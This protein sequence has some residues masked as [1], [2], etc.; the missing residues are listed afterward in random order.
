MQRFLFLVF[1]PKVSSGAKVTVRISYFGERAR[2]TEIR[3]AF[4]DGEDHYITTVWATPDEVGHPRLRR[5][6][7][8][9]AA[10]A[11]RD[12]NSARL[13]DI[14]TRL[15]WPIVTEAELSA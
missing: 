6:I 11:V 15:R 1:A 4:G 9:A 14:L 13:E 8:E 12:T 10:N 7:A 5:L 3:D 2:F